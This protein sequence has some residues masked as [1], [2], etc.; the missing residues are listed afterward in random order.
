MDDATVTLVVLAAAVALFVW[1]RLPVA[2]VALGAALAL[3]AAGVLSLEE[4]VRG[5]GD[6]TPAPDE[7]GVLDGSIEP[8]AECPRFPDA[9]GVAKGAQQRFL[10]RVL[11]VGCAPAYR[12][13]VPAGDGLRPLEQLVDRRRLASSNPVQQLG[14]GA[15]A[16]R[17]RRLAQG[18]RGHDRQCNQSGLL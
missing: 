5:F 10:H 14:V 4:A 12:L 17:G 3:W 7:A 1:N 6:P 13:A 16:A 2:V 18:G 8:R 9:S 11:A 15:V